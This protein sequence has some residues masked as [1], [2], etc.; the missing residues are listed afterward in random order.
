MIYVILTW[1]NHASVVVESRD[2]RLITDPW[3]EGTVFNN[4][5]KLLSPT[6]LRYEDFAGITHIWFSHE[7]PDHFAPANLR[8]I[9]E[10]DRRRIKVLYHETRDRRLIDVCKGF[11]FEVRELPEGKP[12][13]IAPDFRL[14]CR[15]QHLGDSWMAIFAEGQTIRYVES[16]RDLGLQLFDS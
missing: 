6:R 14:L 8:R 11:G 10:E 5:W 13:S 1:V 2:V 12:V 4:G 16:W 7:H 15:P 9:P 3:L